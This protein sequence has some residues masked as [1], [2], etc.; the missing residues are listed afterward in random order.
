MIDHF[1]IGTS[2]AMTVKVDGGRRNLT[3]QA[4]LP[5][6]NREREIQKRDRL[7]AL[8]TLLFL[9]GHRQEMG[10]KERDISTL[11]CCPKTPLGEKLTNDFL[12]SSGDLGFAP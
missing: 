9:K 3:L 2:L 4:S 10:T 8:L 7:V 11:N 6:R 12:V 1:L 5:P